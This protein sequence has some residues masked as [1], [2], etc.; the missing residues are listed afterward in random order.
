MQTDFPVFEQYLQDHVAAFVNGCSGSV[1]ISKASRPLTRVDVLV[2][3]Y[4]C[5]RRSLSVG[6]YW[7]LH[8]FRGTNGSRGEFQLCACSYHQV[9]AYE[10]SIRFPCLCSPS[11]QKKY[12]NMTLKGEAMLN[13]PLPVFR[14]D[15]PENTTPKMQTT[16]RHGTQIPK[17]ETLSEGVPSSLLAFPLVQRAY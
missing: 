9:L 17:C 14:Q 11:K 2:F 10:G 13:E 6:R 15:D 3:L 1:T 12:S 16:F 5:S 8:I 7:C 4:W